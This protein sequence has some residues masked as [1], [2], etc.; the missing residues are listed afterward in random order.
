MERLPGPLRDAPALVD[1]TIDRLVASGE[2][3]RRLDLRGGDD[4]RPRPVVARLTRL[5]DELDRTFVDEPERCGDLLA[6]KG[7]EVVV[8]L[9]E[10]NAVLDLTDGDRILDECRRANAELSAELRAALGAP[11]D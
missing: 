5:V 4:V 9:D 8:V 10:V 11:Q 1:A 2:S 6:V 7:A 3:V